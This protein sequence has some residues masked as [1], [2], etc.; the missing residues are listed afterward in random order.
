MAA[1]QFK[2]MLIATPQMRSES[3]LTLRSKQS[4]V[5]SADPLGRRGGCEP[6]GKICY[7]ARFHIMHRSAMLPGN[8]EGEGQ[9]HSLKSCQPRKSRVTR[10]PRPSSWTRASADKEWRFA[11]IPIAACI[12][13]THPL[14]SRSRGVP[15]F[16]DADAKVS[17]GAPSLRFFARAGTTDAW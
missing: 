13:P 5:R 6:A 15:G 14:R 2:A 1:P 10:W 3:G 16:P 11:P 17:V 8:Q 4:A 9:Q 12:I 7:L